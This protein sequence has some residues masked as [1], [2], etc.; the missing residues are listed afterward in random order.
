[1]RNF[2]HYYGEKREEFGYVGFKRNKSAALLYID[3][4]LFAT[5]T[6][7]FFL[8]RMHEQHYTQNHGLHQNKRICRS[9][10]EILENIKT[11][12]ICA[13]AANF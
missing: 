4:I 10:G 2:L 1:M 8:P 3:K 13:R 5:E 7:N 9:N 12:K 11:K 6:A